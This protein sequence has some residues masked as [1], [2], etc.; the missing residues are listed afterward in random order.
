[1]QIVSGSDSVAAN[2]SCT[3]TTV[4]LNCDITK[5]CF[6]A[7]RSRKYKTGDSSGTMMWGFLF[8]NILFGISRSTSGTSYTNDLSTVKVTLP[9]SYSTYSNEPNYRLYATYYTRDEAR[10]YYGYQYS[11]SY[12]IGMMKAK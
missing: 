11:F 10:D 3:A 4:Q 1:M 12:T 9:F 7:A 2:E 8:D 6:I 5:G